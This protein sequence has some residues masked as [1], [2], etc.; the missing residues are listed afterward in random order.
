MANGLLTPLST[1]DSA[2]D[3][4]NSDLWMVSW[5]G[6]ETCNSRTTKDEGERSPRWSPDGK[7]FE[8]HYFTGGA[9]KKKTKCGFWTSAEARLSSL[10][11][12]KVI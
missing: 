8:F 1:I 5:D 6:Q 12:V 11:N 3:K 2:Q 4:R 9:D 7:I 10:T